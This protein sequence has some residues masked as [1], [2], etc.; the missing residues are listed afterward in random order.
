MQFGDVLVEGRV[1]EVDVDDG[2][3]LQAVQVLVLVVGYLSGG[4]DILKIYIK[5]TKMSYVIQK[6]ISFIIW[7]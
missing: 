5:F 4:G 7:I 6:E 1:E 3:L 2:T